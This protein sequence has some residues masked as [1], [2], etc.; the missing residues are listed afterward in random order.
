MMVSLNIV[1]VQH[2]SLVDKRRQK[3]NLIPWTTTVLR[4]NVSEIHQYR[5]IMTDK[6]YKKWKESGANM[7]RKFEKND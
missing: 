1:V 2:L 7:K 5:D 6:G 3:N 4:R